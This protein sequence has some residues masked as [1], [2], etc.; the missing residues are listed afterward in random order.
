MCK[1]GGQRE[2][3]RESL[4]S[5]WC[6]ERPGKASGPGLMGTLVPWLGWLLSVPRVVP[7]MQALRGPAPGLVGWQPPRG[8]PS[9][10]PTVAFRST[11][12]TWL[13]PVPAS[14]SVRAAPRLNDTWLFPAQA[15]VTPALPLAWA[16]RGCPQRVGLL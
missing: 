3:E 5:S 7:R 12:R 2:R 9:L 8:H 4:A 6:G 10:F 16:P 11:F 1:S 14:C 15:L 13:H